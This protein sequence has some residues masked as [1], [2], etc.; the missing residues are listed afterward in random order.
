M[1]MRNNRLFFF[2]FSLLNLFEDIAAIYEME[3][4]RI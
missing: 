1:K 3:Q 4:Y 2:I